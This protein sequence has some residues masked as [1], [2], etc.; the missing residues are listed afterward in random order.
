M[1]LPELLKTAEKKRF[2]SFDA[3]Q[4]GTFLRFNAEKVDFY[5]VNDWNG[6]TYVILKWPH[7]VPE[8]KIL[9]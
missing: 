1:N 2:S 5:Q 9:P 4:L 8:L 3:N 6:D 7:K